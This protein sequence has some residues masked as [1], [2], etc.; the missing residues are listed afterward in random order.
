MRPLI[1]C[2]AA[3]LTDAPA[4]RRYVAECGAAGLPLYQVAQFDPD[5]WLQDLLAHADGLHLPP[6]YLPTTTYFALEG[7]EILATLRLRHGD[8]L[9]PTSGSAI[10]VMRLAPPAG[11]KASPA[12]CSAGCSAMC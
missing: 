10:S 1:E 9:L 8:N 4:Y 2:R 6:G 5:Q 12:P 3:R 11:V 7:E